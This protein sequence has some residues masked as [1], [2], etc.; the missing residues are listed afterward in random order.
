[1]LSAQKKSQGENYGNDEKWKAWFKDQKHKNKKFANEMHQYFRQM[2]HPLN[3]LEMTD[4]SDMWKA[5][6]YVY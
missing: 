1:M 6:A 2:F 4:N 3:M 5:H